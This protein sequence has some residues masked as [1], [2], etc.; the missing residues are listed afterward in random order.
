MREFALLILPLA[1]PFI[2]ATVSEQD[3]KRGKVRER[4]REHRNLRNASLSSL[5]SRLLDSILKRNREGIDRAPCSVLL[6]SEHRVSRFAV[7]SFIPLDPLKQRGSKR[8]IR[9]SPRVASLRPLKFLQD[10]KSLLANVSRTGDI[11]IAQ[12]RFPRRV[13]R[14]Q[15]CGAPA[16]QKTDASPPCPSK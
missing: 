12:G 4:Y 3:G 14:P 7:W 16:A 2:P 13:V 5:P 9:N 1:S 10:G 8:R 15:K 11:R 6:L